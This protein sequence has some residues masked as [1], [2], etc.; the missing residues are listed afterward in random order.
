MIFI[1]WNRLNIRVKHSTNVQKTIILGI[2]VVIIFFI[3][4]NTLRIVI[5]YSGSYVNC[6][7]MSGDSAV[8]KHYIPPS[9]GF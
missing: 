9:L 2:Y 6:Q 4:N 3:E 8:T 7:N 1:T 5:C